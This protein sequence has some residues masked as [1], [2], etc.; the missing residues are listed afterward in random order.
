MVEYGVLVIL[1]DL[2]EKEVEDVVCLLGEMCCGCQQV[3]EQFKMLIDYQ[4]EYCN[5][6]NSDMSVGIISNCWINYQQFIQMLEKVIIQ[7]C[8]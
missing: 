5:N 6:F 4:N 3:E 8:Q 7:Y 1:K 2:V